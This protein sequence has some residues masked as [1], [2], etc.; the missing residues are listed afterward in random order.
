MD[1]LSI[2]PPN[3]IKGHTRYESCAELALCRWAATFPLYFE[4]SW[5]LLADRTQVVKDPQPLGDFDHFINELKICDR[6]IVD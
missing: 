5:L 3:T 6:L 2:Q 1:V 4:L